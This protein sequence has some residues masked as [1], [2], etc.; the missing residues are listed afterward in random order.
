M[1]FK[2][3]FSNEER[4]IKKIEP[5]VKHIN[6]LEHKIQGLSGDKLQHKTEHFRSALKQG[7][8]LDAILP[9]A[10][11]TVREAAQRTLNQRHYDVQL[12]GGII[13]HQGNIAEMKTGEGKTLVATLPVYLNALKGEGVHVVTVNDYLARR[14]AVW[15]GQIYA[16]LGMTVGVTNTDNQSYLYDPSH[17]N[18]N[19]ESGIRNQENDD[20][21]DTLRDTTGGFHVVHEFLRPC[22]R[23]EAYAADITYGTNNEFGFDYLRS[24]I[25]Y[26]K[27]EVTQ[28]N[29]SYAIVDEIDSILIDEARTPLIISAPSRDP[30]N[31][32]YT[33][34][35]VAAALNKDTDFSIDEKLKATTLTDEGITKAEGILGIDNIYTEKGIKYVHHLENAVRA[36]A[37]FNKDKEYV[38]KE[39]EIVIVDE[40][41]GRLQPG[42]RWSEGLHQAIEAKEGLK[43]QKESRTVAS[44]TFQN[45]FRLYDK[46]A[47]MTGTAQ[48]SAEEFTRVYDLQVVPVPTN[49]P[50][51]RIDR[52]DLILQTE[53]GKFEAVV[54]KIKE[55]NEKNQPVL[56][57]TVSIEKNELLGALLTQKGISHEVL[58]AKNHERE[59][60]II[61]QAGKKGGVTIATNMAG[62]GVDI[63]LGG[64]PP[65]LKDQKEI[66]EVGGLFV[67]GT[68]RHEARR[69][70]NQLRGRS[71]RQGDPGETQ[72][73]VSLEDTLMRVFAS[74]TI[75]NMMGRFGIPEDQPI[76]NKM[77][78]RALESAQ[79]KIEGF[80][81]D[82]RKH[83]L[84]YDDVL[85]HQR[86]MIYTLRRAVLFED[87]EIIKNFLEELTT[88]DP[89]IENTIAEKTKELGKESFFK[90]LAGIILRTI[91]VFWMEHLETMEYLRQ[92][93]SLRAYGQRDPLVEYKKEGLKLFNEMREATNLHVIQL[94]SSIDADSISKIVKER[95]VDV[96]D[97]SASHADAG[98]KVSPPARTPVASETKVGRNDPCPCGSGKK[99]KKCHGM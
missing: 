21:L 5:I 28:R 85:N 96:K 1:I 60:E 12:I 65:D 99:Y 88:F 32:Y 97:V 51:A 56:V 55:L 7:E 92:S 67:I 70:D 42:R 34:A 68:E 58:N 19:Q 27:E 38:V 91:D 80:N 61:A 4:I 6:E 31:L 95:E 23:K 17:T 16:A 33:F 73:F 81:F 40:F 83:V 77:I 48:T 20:E 30:E 50:V 87:K 49:G 98:N 36:K 25:A 84:Q 46:L 89:N 29:F 90:T 9:E 45:Y 54:K 43:V 79:T 3:W 72:F 62:R 86:G 64:N 53:K 52:D 14:D 24:N 37:L 69:I 39:G 35:R 75:K 26:T 2:K 93:V 41:T 94:I 71:G 10:F 11:A 66:L 59:G 15:M 63:V 44:I 74:D 8:T 13:L 57:G 22:T 76:E 78:T 47:G 18:E 82:A